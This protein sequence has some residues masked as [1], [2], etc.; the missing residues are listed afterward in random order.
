MKKTLWNALSKA[1]IKFALITASSV[2]L[3]QVQPQAVPPLPTSM[4]ASETAVILV[5]FQGNFVNPD[6]AW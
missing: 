4:K 3:S 6:G 1:A 5:D 2:A